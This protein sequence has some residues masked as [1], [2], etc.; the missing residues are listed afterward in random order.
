MADPSVE[1][2]VCLVNIAGR[3]LSPAAATF[4]RA[5]QRYRRGAEWSLRLRRMG[6]LPDNRRS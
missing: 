3:Q 2:E 6:G 1:R 5:A 4:A